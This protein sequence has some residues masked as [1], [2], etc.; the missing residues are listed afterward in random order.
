MTNPREDDH[1]DHDQQHP[2][3]AALLALGRD[4]VRVA[5]AGDVRRRQAAWRG[6]RVPLVS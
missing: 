3:I 5:A 4:L 1:D 6:P 2:Q